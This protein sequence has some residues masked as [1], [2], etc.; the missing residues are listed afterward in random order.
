MDNAEFINSLHQ[1]FGNLSSFE[2]LTNILKH[3]SRFII[4]EPYKSFVDSVVKKVSEELTLII[5]AN[6]VLFRARINEINF[7]DREKEKTPFSPE[8]MGP[9]PSQL[10]KPGRINPEG[11]PYLYCAG[12]LD[13]AGA[14]LRP[15]MGAHLTMAEIKIN[16][17][18]AIADL[19]SECKDE[20]WDL[21]F[22]ELSLSFSTQWPPE[23]KLNYLI[24]QYFSEHF[25]AVGL[26]GVKYRSEFNVGGDNYALFYG[27][28]YS[29]VKTYSIE[30]INVGFVFYNREPA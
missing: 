24:T 10:A 30:T 11:I 22:D 3:E 17:D 14:E 12:D 29:V 2:S 13:T 15:W 19:T 8:E 21:F 20:L 27:E 7:K 16:D 6:T 26:R 1:K 23:L 18:I 9:P 28:D 25:K 5:P 4:Q